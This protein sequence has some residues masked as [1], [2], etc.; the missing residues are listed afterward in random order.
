MADAPSGLDIVELVADQHKAVY[1]YAY[2][3]T[4]SVQD[5]EDLAQQ[6]FLIAQSKIGQLRKIDAA[7][8]WLFAILRNC[9]LKDKQRRHPGLAV[10]LALNVDSIA[11]ATPPAEVDH[12]QLQ[13]AL[14]RLPDAFR[15]V[16]VMF[17]FEERSY[18]E[19]ADELKVPIGTVMSRLARA[20]ADLRSRLLG[21]KE[22][23]A[24]RRTGFQPVATD[25]KS[26]RRRSY[27]PHSA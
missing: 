27:F 26:V 3:L 11:E 7:G 22:K 16:V 6:V 25:R 20:K 19:I 5:A 9:F 8:S 4:G 18:R 13:E 15:L 21:T 23:G 10:D 2:R 14:N 24:V 17:Y 1:R 12:G